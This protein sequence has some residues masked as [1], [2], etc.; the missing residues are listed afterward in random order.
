MTGSPKDPQMTE[1][2]A[3]WAAR[4]LGVD[5]D[6]AAKQAR[7]RICEDFQYDKREEERRNRI[8]GGCGLD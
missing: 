4:L 1:E 3:R 5:P 8:G 7:K 2:D 6:E